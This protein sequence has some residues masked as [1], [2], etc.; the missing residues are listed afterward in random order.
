M[1]KTAYSSE[2]LQI[3]DAA[4]FC[5][6]VESLVTG[7]RMGYMDSILHLCQTRNMEPEMAATLLSPA[8]RE[9]IRREATRLNM[10]RRTASLPF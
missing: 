5:S 9:H 1:T 6:D 8:I 10:I 7:N 4:Q 2:Q 3:E